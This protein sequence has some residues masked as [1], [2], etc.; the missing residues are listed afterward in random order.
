MVLQRALKDH[1]EY[2]VCLCV[3]QPR[4]TP[5]GSNVELTVACASSPRQIN[6]SPGIQLHGQ[7]FRPARKALLI[8]ER[9]IHPKYKSMP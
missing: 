4:W 1:Y 7:L 3:H 5:K 6:L 8:E 2:R 9:L